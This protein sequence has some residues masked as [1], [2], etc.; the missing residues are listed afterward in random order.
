MDH[1][2]VL[3]GRNGDE[4]ETTARQCIVAGANDV[5]V[6]CVDVT[7]GA[8]MRGA[9]DAAVSERGLSAV[10]WV[11]G[12]FDWGPAETADPA[13]WR[14][15]IDVNLTSAAV[16][17]TMVLPALIDAAPSALV[18]IGSGASRQAFA[19]NAAYV[20]SKH[21]L[22]GLA[23]A[24]FLDVRDRGVKVSLV[25]PGLVAAG[26][27]LLSPAG[28]TSPHELLAPED[29]AAAVDFVV[30]FPPTGCPT[31][32]QLQPQKVAIRTSLYLP[33]SS[34]GTC[35]PPAI[36]GRSR[37]LQCLAILM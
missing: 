28:A 31:E 19:N 15:L 27:G 18:F 33:D 17:T 32:I 8:A 5:V 4:L 26:A 9:V 7:D 6:R 22:A 1:A 25:S 34:P 14:R 10:V 37:P 3:W 11:A 21:G 16:L 29:V 36:S 12:L 24:T 20:A 30:S 35:R 23:G 13:V 2:L